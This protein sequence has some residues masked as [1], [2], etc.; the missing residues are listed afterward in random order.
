MEYYYN[1]PAGSH[2]TCSKDSRIEEEEKRKRNNVSMATVTQNVV[3][4]LYSLWFV[5]SRTYLFF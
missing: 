5:I 1:V 4:Y 2:F 3:C